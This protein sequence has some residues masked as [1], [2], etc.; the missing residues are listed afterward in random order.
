MRPSLIPVLVNYFQGRSCQIKWR[1]HLSKRRLLPGSGAQG[2]IIGNYEFLSQ[3]NNNVDHIPEEDRWKWVDDL[4]SLEV[5]DLINAGLSS[6]NF[7]QHV[8]SDIDVNGQFLDPNNLKTQDYI[9]T[10]ETW[11]DQQQMKLYDKKTKIMLIYF[12]KKYQFNTRLRL[13]S[14]IIEQVLQVKILGAILNDQLTWDK[15]CKNIIK[16]NV[17]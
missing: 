15:N 2:S 1:G 17:T 5:I 9:S 16:K 10:L 13:K 3:T 6:Y 8:A 12:T 14:S 7:R 11:S 4:T